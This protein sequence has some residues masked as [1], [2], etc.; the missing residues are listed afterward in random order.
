MLLHW[1]VAWLGHQLDGPSVTVTT[2][3]ALNA[4]DDAIANLAEQQ[5]DKRMSWSNLLDGFPLFI[6]TMFGG[7]AVSKALKLVGQSDRIDTESVSRISSAAMDALVVAAITTLNLAAVIELAVPFFIILVAGCAWAVFLP[8]RTIK[9]DPS[10]GTLVPAGSDQLRDV[11]G[12]DR[13][14][15]CVTASH[16]P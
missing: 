16:R 15:L 6:F 12:N 11:H 8:D 1:S 2:D 5:L 9:V 7:L 3:S 13:N 10:I 14:R 4:T